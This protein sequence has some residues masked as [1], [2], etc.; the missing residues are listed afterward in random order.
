MAIFLSLY[1]QPTFAKHKSLKLE[2][3]QIF[4]KLNIFANARGP[5]ASISDSI[6]DNTDGRG[7][8]LAAFPSLRQGYAQPGRV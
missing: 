4:A 3:K 7:L 6:L 2:V 1:L 8:V 5:R